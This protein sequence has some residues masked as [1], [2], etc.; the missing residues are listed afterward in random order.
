MKFYFFGHPIKSKSPVI[1]EFIHFVNTTPGNLTIGLSSP[2]GEVGVSLFI[3]DL[4][5]R[6]KDRI[7]LIAA[8]I[9]H[10]AAF[11]IWAGFKGYKSVYSGAMGMTHM[12]DTSVRVTEKGKAVPDDEELLQNSTSYGEIT[13]SIT[14]PVMT[15]KQISLYE[16]GKDVFFTCDNLRK[17]ATKQNRSHKAKKPA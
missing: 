13:K 6:N 17:I 14:F 10:S 3:L 1:R 8:G 7:H 4:L 15:Q 12:A 16:S 5:N 2:G 9:V 11:D